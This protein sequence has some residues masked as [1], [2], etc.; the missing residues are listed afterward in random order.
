MADGE[1]VAG[2]CS[3]AAAT[4]P[5]ARSIAG[6]D[7]LAAGTITVNGHRCDQL[8]PSKRP[9]SIVF[10]SLALYPHLSAAENIAFPLRHQG[11]E[12]DVIADRR[13][14]LLALLKL[15]TVAEA[16]PR[17][18]GRLDRVRVAIARAIAKRPGLIVLDDPLAALADEDR[19]HARAHLRSIQRQ[20][21]SAMLYLTCN[22]LDATIVGDRIAY[23]EDRQVRQTDTP[24]HLYAN[25]AT[26]GVAAAIG[27]PPRINFIPARGSSDVLAIAGQNIT[28]NGSLATR[29]DDVPVLV[30]IRPEAFD[31]SGTMKNSLLAILDPSTRQSMGSFSI[32]Q[33]QVGDQ[34]VAVQIPGNPTDVPRRA[35]AAPESLLLFD[36]ETGERIR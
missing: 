18:L 13:D 19:L 26:R 32:V 35:Y 5:I 4:G 25:P 8:H 17:Q 12:D 1:A 20:T 6:L 34:A 10:R 3:S 29:F 24:A 22:G 11:V 27:Q 33:G 2:L 36:S 14:E 28:L 15:E 9:I 16:L 30:G 31:I 23:I 7:D 21:Q